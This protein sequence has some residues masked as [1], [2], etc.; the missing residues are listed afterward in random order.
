M[1]QQLVV[2]RQPNG[3]Q[4]ELDPICVEKAETPVKAVFY[5]AAFVRSILPGLGF[6]TDTQPGAMARLENLE[7]SSRLPN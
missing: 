6:Y 3:Q 2:Y 5:R 1:R 7:V 4:N